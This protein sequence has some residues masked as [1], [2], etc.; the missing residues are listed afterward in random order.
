LGS[1]VKLLF[2][3]S[4]VPH[5]K[6]GDGNVETRKSKKPAQGGNLCTGEHRTLEVQQIENATTAHQAQR[7][8]RLFSLSLTLATVVAELAYAESPR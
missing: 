6:F 2:L 1:Q 5:L 3:L 7:L 4:R 8:H